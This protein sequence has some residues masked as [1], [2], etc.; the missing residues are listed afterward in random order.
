[1][2]RSPSR[3]FAATLFCSAALLFCVQPMVG[4][5]LLPVLGGSPQVWSTCLV[6]FQAA[7]LAGYGLAHLLATR[8]PPRRQPALALVCAVL[9][10]ASLPIAL[11][12]AAAAPS[13]SGTGPIFWTLTVLLTA[14]G[15]A[16]VALAVNGPLLQRWYAWSGADDAHDPYFLYAASNA[17][18]FVGLLGYPLLIEPNL[19]TAAQAHW[20]TV[21]Y[22][23]LIALLVASA[24]AAF[25]RK[26]AQNMAHEPVSAGTDGEPSAAPVTFATQL[27]WIALAAVPSSLLLGVTTFL[28]TDLAAIPL[29]WVVPLALYLAT[30]IATFASRPWIAPRIVASALPILVVGW[31]LLYLTEATEPAWALVSFHLLTFVA[32]ALLCHGR[33]AEQRPDPQHLTRFFLAT[34]VGGV[35][36]GAFNAL[37]APAIF[38]DL[39]EY[40]VAI[41]AACLCLPRVSMPR[42]WDL[43]G[44]VSV[45]A[46]TVALIYAGEALGVPAGPARTVMAFGIPVLS[47]WLLVDRPTRFALAVVA[48]LAVAPLSPSPTGALVASQRSFFGVQRVTTDATGRFHQV[49]H[50][51]TLHG[52]QWRDG[53]RQCEPLAYYHPTGP[54]GDVV[55]GWPHHFDNVAMIGVGAGSMLSYRT[56][57]SRWLVVD[58]DPATWTLATDHFSFL[59]GCPEQLGAAAHEGTE[60]VVADGRRAIADLPKARLFRAIVVDVFSSDAIPVHMLTREAFDVYAAHLASDGILV[61]HASNRYLD[62]VSV[63]AAVAKDRG[64]SALWRD[65]RSSH[66]APGSEPSRWLVAAVKPST[67]AP[68]AADQRFASD[69]RWIAPHAHDRV[70]TDDFNDLPRLFAMGVLR[71]SG[72]GPASE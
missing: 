35:L 58:I 39:W 6:F 9:P 57:A 10:I 24:W 62:V 72:F 27:G 21:G 14:V 25:G 44:P 23:A 49:V 53:P 18:S 43:V 54:L 3:I 32:A 31:L 11:P 34:S 47:A 38:A 69:Q 22:G 48:L 67:L 33:L 65:D 16:F 17:G 5:L 68:F 42:A 71:A 70:W 7:L 36:G 2:T 12:V 51:H 66:R 46:A 63:L 19:G 61:F 15:P 28:T 1:M 26:N 8:V 13:T 56:A 60:L 59:R 4:R 37:L 30:W 50:G 64:M 20:W 52:R 29:L 55:H 41:V 45:A 40:P